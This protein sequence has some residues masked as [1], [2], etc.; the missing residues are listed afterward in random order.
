MVC[1]NCMVEITFYWCR[2]TRTTHTKPYIIRHMNILNVANLAKMSP[3]S[4][5]SKSRYHM[6]N[7]KCSACPQAPSILGLFLF[8]LGWSLS[9]VTQHIQLHLPLQPTVT[10]LVHDK[11]WVS[12]RVLHGRNPDDFDTLT[13]EDNVLKK[14]S[15]ALFLLYFQVI[16]SEKSCSKP[17]P[18]FASIKAILWSPKLLRTPARSGERRVAVPV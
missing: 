12:L 17:E 6:R 9:L 8:S 4:L 15:L 1:Y 11:Q 18:G 10:S 7:M 16:C 2:R 3:T 13:F 5:L 14:T